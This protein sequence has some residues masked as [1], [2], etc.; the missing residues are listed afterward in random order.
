MSSTVPPPTAVRR[1]RLLGLVLLSLLAAV[2]IVASTVQI[3][4]GAYGGPVIVK[5]LP[6][7]CET[8]L[9]GAQ[10]SLRQAFLTALD[11]NQGKELESYDKSTAPIVKLLNETT[12]QACGPGWPTVLRATI[13]LHSE[14]RALLAQHVEHVVPLEQEVKRLSSSHRQSPEH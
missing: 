11:A 12:L 5:T 13:E 7:V 4:T 1:A 6:A 2:F 10:G 3:M 9:Q 8:M 14:R